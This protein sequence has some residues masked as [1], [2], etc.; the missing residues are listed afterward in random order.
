MQ[1]G[2]RATIP[3]DCQE[4][5]RVSQGSRTYTFRSEDLGFESSGLKCIGDLI[6]RLLIVDINQQAGNEATEDLRDD[7][8]GD[9]APWE[10]FEEGEAD[11]EAWVEVRTGDRTANH[12]CEGDTA[13]YYGK[14]SNWK[15]HDRRAGKEQDAHARP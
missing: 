7:I 13:S 12:N 1:V 15:T 11:C 14:M 4:G 10:T 2:K 3:K 6:Q 5:I 8:L 9:F